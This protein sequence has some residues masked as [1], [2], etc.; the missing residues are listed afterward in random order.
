MDSKTVILNV[1]G[2][3]YQVL[4]DSLKKHRNTR[5]AKLRNEIINKNYDEIEKLCDSFSKNLKEF[6][7]DRDPYVLN[8]VLNYNLNKRLHISHKECVYFIRDE[9]EYW[10]IDEFVLENCC[11]IIYFD[12]LEEIEGLI[13]SEE[14]LKKKLNHKED[15]GTS[16]YPEI[17]EKLW[18]LFDNPKSSIYAKVYYFLIKLIIQNLKIILS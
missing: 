17:R 16:F 14:M 2:I 12:K 5:L 10:Q 1:R 3:K 7:F 15:F 18:N 6:Y 4:L 9:L 11:K 8:M 13:E